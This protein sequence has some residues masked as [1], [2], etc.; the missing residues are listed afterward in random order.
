MDMGIVRERLATPLNP[1]LQAGDLRPAAVLLLFYGEP[2]RLIM[3]KKSESMRVHAGEIS[4]PGGKPE[5][6]DTDLCD[7]A[8]RETR[9]EI[10]LEASRRD[11]IGQ[12]APVQTLNSRFSILPFV[13]ALREIPRL[14]PN[15]EV[16]E[17]FRI[18]LKPFLDTVA[19]D[20]VHGPGMF[21]FR[22]GGNTVWGASARILYHVRQAMI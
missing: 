22:Y 15:T 11:V 6:S 13:A 19:P 10:G 21:T 5:I 12:L 2:P 9:E 14:V 18:P 4:F 20:A 8:L 17:I 7:T 1:I 16:K 3:T